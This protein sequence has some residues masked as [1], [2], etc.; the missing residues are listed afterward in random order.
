MRATP[1]QQA[2]TPRLPAPE[3]SSPP[4][5]LPSGV[6]VGLPQKWIRCTDATR[7]ENPA[8][9]E[10]ADLC[11]VVKVRSAHQYVALSGS[12][13]FGFSLAYQ[14]DRE[15]RDLLPL[16]GPEMLRELYRRMCGENTRIVSIDVTV[17]RCEL[18]A[19]AIA[20]RKSLAVSFWL[21]DRTSGRTY[22][23]VLAMVPFAEGALLA[24]L[25]AA[26]QDTRVDFSDV[27][28]VFRSITLSDG[29]GP[30]A[31]PELVRLNPAP[32]FS[33]GIP[34]GWVACDDGDNTRLGGLADTRN[35]C[36]D[37]DRG[38]FIVYN[39][40]T[41]RTVFMIAWHSDEKRLSETD[42]RELPSGRISRALSDRIC[43]G[44]AARMQ[45]RNFAFS[46]CASEV[47]TVGGRPAF[48][49]RFVTVERGGRTVSRFD[50]R[51]FIVPYDRGEVMM[52]F[53]TPALLSEATGPIITA[54]LASVEIGESI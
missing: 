28:D 38:Q 20:G 16:L 32:G 15:L 26:G 51:V 3:S 27:D 47:A 34:K 49:L 31:L 17:T 1:R 7:A 29:L 19:P 11:R 23:A 22:R 37:R 14:R 42:L 13:H 43:A 33:I 41:L 36:R 53:L 4:G 45:R 12:P 35:G 2:P 30:Q 40:E 10:A 8:N 24:T 48:S 6:T 5:E 46:E 54:L 9:A 50:S 39:P 21:K 44:I 25:S 52:V 18:S